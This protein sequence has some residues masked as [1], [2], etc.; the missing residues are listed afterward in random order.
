MDNKYAGMT[1]NE[2]LY[3]SGLMD[4]FD[5]AVKVNDV[6]NVISI[7]KEVELTDESIEPILKQ[8]GLAISKPSIEEVKMKGQEIPLTPS[9]LYIGLKNNW[10]TSK[11]LVNIINTSRLGYDEQLIIDLNVNEEDKNYILEK[12][13]SS[14]K[15][16]ENIGI[17]VWQFFYL[18]EIERQNKT[19]QEKLKEIVLQWSRFGCPDE[20]RDFIYYLPNKKT[21]SEEDVYKLFLDYLTVEKKKINLSGMGKDWGLGNHDVI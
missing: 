20:W 2:R 5:I 9:V 16:D 10:I 11:E 3:V 21:H 18:S 4:K 15:I 19:L 6:K 7:L 17:K 14:S 12:L 1:V 13:Y 8:F